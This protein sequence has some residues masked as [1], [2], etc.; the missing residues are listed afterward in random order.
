MKE[1]IK[2][3]SPTVDVIQLGHEGQ[4]MQ[5][6]GLPDY[7]DGGDPLGIMMLP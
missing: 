2:Y 7:S 6:S 3:E 4:I 1:L 5:M